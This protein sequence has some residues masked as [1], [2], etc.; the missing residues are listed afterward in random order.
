MPKV[1]DANRKWWTLFAIAFSL[2]IINLDNTVVVVALP[3]IRSDLGMSFSSIEWIV[4]AYTLVFA[5]LLL[6]GGKLAD[7]F[8]RKRIL[9]IGLVIFEVS[10]LICAL[11]GDGAVL[12]S[13]RSVQGA[14]AALM[15]PA[16]LS[17]VSANFAPS[18]RGMAFG[19]WAGISALALAIGPLV[20][21]V[22]VD[23][24]NWRWIFYINIPIGLIGFATVRAIVRES[25]DETVGQGFDIPGLLI[26]AL[27][28]FAL[29][30]ALTE[31]NRYG[32]G[33]ATTVGLLAAAAVGMA[34]FVAVERRSRESL[35]DLS[36][37][38]DP[39]FTGAN[40]VGFMIMFALF[41]TLIYI[42]IFAQDVLFYSALK[43]GAAFMPLTVLLMVSAPI[44]GKLSD[45]M[46]SGGPMAIGMA[47]FGAALLL[48][49]RLGATW[50]FWDMLP[51]FALA[52]VGFG[53]TLPASTAAA[54]SRV[55]D[56]KTGVASGVLNTFRQF[57][58]ALG[59]A[60][61]GAIVNSSVR[62]SLPG[63]PDFG[64]R[65][66]TGTHNGLRVAAFVALA[67][68]LVAAFT[69][70]QPAATPE[71]RAA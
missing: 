22:L 36:V 35:L 71:A 65:F 57:G 50:G 63:D 20:G 46:G 62:S 30:F 45:E 53:L 56:D 19:I 49:S 13:A 12:I 2:F 39:T 23:G 33:S 24:I 68:A 26:G 51:A 70:R 66:V 14:G 37:F 25:R 58:G 67:G 21:G 28:T 41:G 34:A 5:V 64:S 52:G 60:V 40:V 1:T 7:Y 29:V 54:L 8:G 55:P 42:S 4:N 16:T 17:L 44:G 3:V 43:A 59:L 15:L 11:A 47:L 9:L 69:I 38:R 27:A 48:L 31:A 61:V 32:W 6:F 18:E 10:S